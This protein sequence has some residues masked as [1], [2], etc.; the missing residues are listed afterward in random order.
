M[1]TELL[2]FEQLLPLLLRHAGQPAIEAVDLAQAHGRIL[3]ASA[4]A[5][6]SMPRFDASAMDGYAVRGADCVVG[7][8]QLRLQRTADAYAGSSGAALSPG[9]CMAIGTGGRIPPGADCVIPKEDCRL[10]DSG[11][12]VVSGTHLGQ[13]IR[14]A[15]EEFASGT[16]L[17]TAGL[18]VDG[19][20][21]A[22]LRS[23]GVSQVQVFRSVQVAVVTTGN[24]VAADPGCMSETQ[25]LDTNG[26]MLEQLLRDDG[27]VS[28]R[29]W[30][31][32]PDDPAR[33]AQVLG[34]AMEVSD[35]VLIAG[36]V[37]VGDRDYVKAV[38]EQTLG[39]ERL[40]WGVAVKPGKPL[41]VGQRGHRL[42]VGM[43]GN[44]GSVAAQWA[45][46][47]RALLHHMQGRRST[48][49]CPLP[50]AIDPQVKRERGKTRLVWVQLQRGHGGELLA[51]PLPYA[52]SHMLR[53][54][55]GAAGIVAVP[56]AE[57]PMPARLPLWLR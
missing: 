16:E 32:V 20:T 21:L 46:V 26:P 36:G 35:L 11:I 2:P 54:I 51:H 34:E 52:A 22:L 14:R 53:G 3:A 29:H 43:P 57:T 24:E 47:V 10:T 28:A 15:G 5:R 4:C 30:G 45:T 49:W 48:E 40:V 31:P 38:L 12:T 50:V 25:I 39:C 33:L 27:G 42:V 6:W 9:C 56:P 19:Y 55:A 7:G 17:G 44:P 41:Y 18:V 37:S 23:A 8:A 13:H 1:V